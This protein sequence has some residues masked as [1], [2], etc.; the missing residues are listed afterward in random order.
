MLRA[1]KGIME[2]K[3]IKES[4]AFRGL[5]H[6]ASKE[7]REKLGLRES[8]ESKAFR[9]LVHRGS[10]EIR[11]MLEL[12]ESKEIVERASREKGGLR[13]NRR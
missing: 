7:I 11:E 9:G 8:K 6:K 5:A 1:F 4:N 2:I 12:R 10:K 3:G 13:G